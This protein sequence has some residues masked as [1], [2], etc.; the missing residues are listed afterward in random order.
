MGSEGSLLCPQQ[1]T[2]GPYPKPEA[3][4]TLYLS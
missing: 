1:P 3:Y 4:E 2:T